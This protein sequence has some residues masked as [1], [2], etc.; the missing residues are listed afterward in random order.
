MNESWRNVSKSEPCPICG[1]ATWCSIAQDGSAAIC[2][3]VESDKPAGE[4]PD[5]GWVH[6]L[7]D[8]PSEATKSKHTAKSIPE[9]ERFS[10]DVPALRNRH[11]HH[12][13]ASA[14]TVEVIQERGYR[15]VAG[16]QELIDA[17]FV[18]KSQQR[19]GGILIPVHNPTGAPCGYIYKPDSPRLSASNSKPIKY[20]VPRGA[21]LHLDVPL[22]CNGRI[23]DPKVRIWI[24]EGA[25][26]ADALASIGECS[27]N[28]NGVYGYL[29][30]NEFGGKTLL[31]DFELIPWNGGREVILAFDSDIIIKKEVR[32][33]LE[34]LAG[35]L[36]DKGSQVSL[37]NLPLND[38]G[39]KVGVDDYLAGGHSLGDLIGLC[40]SWEPA[41]RD[42]ADLEVQQAIITRSD[43]RFCLVK[44]DGDHR[45][46]SPLSN[47]TAG[48]SEEIVRDDGQKETRHFVINGSLE[49]GARLPAIE[50]EAEEFP[51]MAWVVKS[52]GNRAFIAPG[53]SSK[54]YLRAAIQ[55]QIKDTPIRRVYE[56]TGWRDVD[57]ERYYLSGSGALGNPA[58]EVELKDALARYRLP[59]NPDEV[60]RVEAMQESL[61]LLDFGNPYVMY[62]MW[63][64]MYLAPLTEMLNPA[65]TMFL[66]GGSGTFKSTISSLFLNHFGKFDGPL[67]L[68]ASWEATANQL[69][70]VCFV[71]KDAVACIDDWYPGSTVA[72]QRAME[73]LAQKVIRSQGNRTARGRMRSDLTVATT[74][75]PRGLLLTSGEQVPGG[76]SLSARLFTLTL[77]RDDIDLSDLSA[78]QASQALYSY[79]MAHYLNWL[80]AHWSLVEAAPLAW[81][82]FRDRARTEAQHLRL[83]AVVAW[84]YTGLDLAMKYAVDVKALTEDAAEAHRAM[85]W[86]HLMDLADRQGG[87]VEEERAANR[88]IAAMAT[89]FTQ[90][91]IFTIPKDIRAPTGEPSPGKT[92]VGWRDTEYYYLL[93]EAA[94]GVASEFASHVSA[95]TFKPRAVWADLARLNMIKVKDEKPVVPTWIGKGMSD[96]SQRRVIMLRRKVIDG[97]DVSQA[98]LLDDNGPEQ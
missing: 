60:D 12:L 24:T 29:G 52:W 73:A 87:A 42:V 6:R 57:G 17:G 53:S 50:V 3:R 10:A 25:K 84:L 31:P 33:A 90:G 93:P 30:K 97:I 23:K 65:F 14:I 13:L 26:K 68:P 49:S 74:Y 45:Y 7:G 96:G 51:A 67:D 32:L 54:D 82:Q 40:K 83:P 34:R 92:F 47:F 43:G 27:V 21:Q 76:Q 58:I 75:V 9:S 91:K 80:K 39:S 56:H 86:A 61:K 8:Q 89:L 19:A 5:S 66:C 44:K 62:P 35:I 4:K 2:R 94:Y 28:L 72:D 22:R 41:G 11:L 15:S 64:L 88:F 37:L 78:A 95:F 98:E 16:V 38:D 1:K 63:A 69:G 59:V 36:V 46:R 77:E 48:V 18:A 55:T 20:E 85:A 81:R 79:A 70:W 71:L